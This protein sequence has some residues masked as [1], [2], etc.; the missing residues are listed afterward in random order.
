MPRPA[1]GV[2]FLLCISIS[3]FYNAQDVGFSRSSSTYCVFTRSYYCRICPPSSRVSPVCLRQSPTGRDTL[4]SRTLS[5]V[6]SLCHSLRWCK[7]TERTRN[8]ALLS[9]ARHSLSRRPAPRVRNFVM[10]ERL[11]YRVFTMRKTWVFYPITLLTVSAL[12]PT[13]LIYSRIWGRA[14]RVA[15]V[16]C[17]S[18]RSPAWISFIAR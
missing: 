1:L 12:R 3:R 17:I 18:T 4:G 2:S 14:E 10:R 5:A 11:E 13:L 7:K 15:S 6:L 8:F 16:G 9:G